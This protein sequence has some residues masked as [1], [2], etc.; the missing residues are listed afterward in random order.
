MCS[1]QKCLLKQIGND[2]AKQLSHKW[3]FGPKILDDIVCK[4]HLYKEAEDINTLLCQSDD[5]YT[6]DTQT[7]NNHLRCVFFLAD[8]Y[9]ILFWYCIS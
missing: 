8:F 6:F 7:L 5:I 1:F 3:Y 4:S 9:V 2:L